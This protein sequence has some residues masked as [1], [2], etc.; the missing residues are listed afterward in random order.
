MGPIYSEFSHG[1]LIQNC[2]PGYLF[3]TRNRPDFLH[4]ATCSSTTLF[5]RALF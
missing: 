1:E 2:L 3:L 5:V 4:T